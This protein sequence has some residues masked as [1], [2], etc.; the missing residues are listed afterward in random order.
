MTREEKIEFIMKVE[1][2]VQNACIKRIAAGLKNYDSKQIF[3]SNDLKMAIKVCRWDF[4]SNV[5]K[6]S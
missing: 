4:R 2:D 6:L 1:K 5:I 3:E